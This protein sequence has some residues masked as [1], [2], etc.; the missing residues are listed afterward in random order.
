MPNG[1]GSGYVKDKA[2]SALGA[3]IL[4]ALGVAGWFLSRINDTLDAHTIIITQEQAYIE[5]IKPL[6]NVA[7]QTA[8]TLANHEIRIT[9]LENSDR[10]Q[11]K[12]IGHNIDS[13]DSYHNETIGALKNLDKEIDVLTA[14]LSAMWT[15]IAHDP[16]ARLPQ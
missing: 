16:K 1:D 6:A 13:Q 4:V 8:T 12:D 15:A 10:Q 5:S 14:R 11:E 2:I 3:L 7:I 9:N